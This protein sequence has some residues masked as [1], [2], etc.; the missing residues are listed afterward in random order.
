SPQSVTAPNVVSG[1]TKT[2]I[3]HLV[4]VMQQNHTFDNYFGTYPNA[5]GIPPGTCIPIS[6]S[7]TTNEECI[8]PFHIGEYPLADLNHGMRIFQEEY[9][10]GQMNGFMEALYR[11]N[12]D[13]KLAMAYYD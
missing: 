5:N 6:L 3:E 11:R 8:A 1:T 10:R 4:V 2:P 7:D 13:G 12:Q 9:N